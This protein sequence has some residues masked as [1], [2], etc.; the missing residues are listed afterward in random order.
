MGSDTWNK[1]YSL[2]QTPMNNAKNFIKGIID[3]IKGFFNFKISFPH[4][5]LPHFN[6]R[7][8]GWGIGDLLKGKIPS[9]GIE[10]YKKAYDQPYVFD[11]PTVV[12]YGDKLRGFGDGNGKEIAYGHENLM[13][14]IRQATKENS[15]N[16]ELL[17]KVIDKMD[18]ILNAMNRPI[19]LDNGAL[20]GYMLDDIDAWL[21]DV[22]S[23]KLRGVK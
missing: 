18:R 20:V 9:L 16:D 14:D 10:W 17:M 11:E 12:N 6:I 3:T 5:P 21:G 1:V 4:I 7:P 13:D 15:A 8:S 22:A 2:I 23:L 19:V